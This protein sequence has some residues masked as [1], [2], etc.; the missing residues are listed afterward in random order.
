MMEVLE[1]DA[2]LRSLLNEKDIFLLDRGFRDCIEE[3][4]SDYKLI[5]HMPKFIGKENKQ[6]TTS[7]ANMTR[8]VTKCRWIIEVI[9][10]FLKKSFK[11]IREVRNQSLPHT[12]EDY[13]IA[14]ALVNKFFKRLFSD[15]DDHVKIVENMKLKL[16]HPNELQDIITKKELHKKSKFLKLDFIEINDFPKLDF[17]DIKTNIT[18]GTYQLKQALGYLAANKKNGKYEIMIN[19]ELAELKK[20]KIIYAAIQSRHSN[21]IKYK[22]YVKYAPK[23][24]GLDS[25][26]SWY[27]TCKNGMRTVGCCS[28]VASIIYYYSCG[29][30]LSQQADPAGNLRKI[31][32]YS[33]K[34][35][36]SDASESSAEDTQPDIDR[37]TLKKK[38]S[39]KKGIYL[40]LRIMKY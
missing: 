21:S 12:L 2:E 1:N 11:A 3:L 13:K 35:E 37:K 6:F 5:V 40:F 38:K 31:F 7:E 30:Y 33:K 8:F 9:N 32:P 24:T 20:S 34:K 26:E 10:S 28:H 39:T 16:N 14:G 4:E 15:R 22:V 36:S 29:K 23:M 18:L 17:E 19:K 27:C 25:I